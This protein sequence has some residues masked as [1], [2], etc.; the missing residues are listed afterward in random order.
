MNDEVYIWPY[1]DYPEWSK[2]LAKNYSRK[3]IEKQLSKVWSDIPS[4]VKS[5]INAINKTSSMQSN[6][7]ARAQS[8]NVITGLGERKMALLNAL[9]I[10]DHYPEKTMEGA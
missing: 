2:Q 7:Q 3:D 10:Y 1:K 4:A 8:G 5:H 6:S 9:E